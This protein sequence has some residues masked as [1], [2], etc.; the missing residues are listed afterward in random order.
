MI[1]QGSFT[2]ENNATPEW[3]TIAPG[4]YY[5]LMIYSYKLELS[6]LSVHVHAI[7]EGG[8]GPLR[9]ADED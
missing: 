3:I 8:I 9:D 7:I 2:K 6:V 4:P 5:L 1:Y